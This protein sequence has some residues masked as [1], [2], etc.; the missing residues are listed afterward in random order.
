MRL[1]WPVVAVILFNLWQ[2]PPMSS[3]CGSATGWFRASVSPW[4]TL[5]T[6]TEGAF[7]V[8]AFTPLN[9]A[10]CGLANY[11]ERQM[12]GES[13]WELVSLASLVLDTDQFTV[14]FQFKL[15][16]QVPYKFE[17]TI[18]NLLMYH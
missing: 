15:G 9:G 7:C 4:V 8:A 12:G 6:L 3:L 5:W 10:L 14:P 11:A 18:K 2:K 17:R 1:A 13:S 16:N